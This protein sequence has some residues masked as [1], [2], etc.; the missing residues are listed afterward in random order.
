MTDMGVKFDL[1]VAEK[2]VE[3]GKPEVLASLHD[4]GRAG[5]EEAQAAH[6]FATTADV[7]RPVELMGDHHRH[8]HPHKAE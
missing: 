6:A 7:D 1:E 8:H 4:P 5:T 2:G 3:Q